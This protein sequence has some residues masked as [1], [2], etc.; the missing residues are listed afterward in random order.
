MKQEFVKVSIIIPVYKV[1]KYLRKCLDSVIAQTY[2]NIEIILVDDGSPDNCG[3]ICDEYAHKNSYM[4]VIHQRNQGQAAARNNAVKLATGNLILFIDSDDFVETDCVEY[5]VTL[6]QKYNADV[7]IGGFKYLYE[8]NK[9]EPRS[10]NEQVILMNAEEA[11]IRIN[12]GVGFGATPWAKLYKRDLICAH[13]FP[14][15]QIYEDLATLYKILGD[16]NTIVYGN[17][18]IYYWL[19]R[20]DST[21]H[22]E[23]DERQMAGMTAV[24]EQLVY[25]KKHY[26]NVVPTAKARYMAKIAELMA[27]A[28][29]SENSK[30]VYK[31]LKQE[32]LYYNDVMADPQVKT[33]MKFRLRSLMRGYRTAG[34]MFTI[35]EFMKKLLV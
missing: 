4:R 6:Q 26:P 25:M 10:A 24:Q 23:F 5:L 15:G 3:S 19:Q 9:V 11:L 14:V 20:K 31:R 21:M 32:M 29:K 30:E 13:P 7:A 28:F 33:S 12:Y 1:E 35:H 18:R 16:A 2:K 8:G 27:I 22:M 34:L 17:R